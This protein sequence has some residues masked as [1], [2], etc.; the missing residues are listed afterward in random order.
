[1]LC[2]L[3]EVYGKNVMSDGA[4]RKLVREF[5][6]EQTKCSFGIDQVR[7]FVNTDNLQ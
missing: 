5:S 3:V 4:V 7:L 1:M 6:A 2:E